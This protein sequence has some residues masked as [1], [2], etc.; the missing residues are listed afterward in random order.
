MRLRIRRLSVLVSLVLLTAACKEET[1]APAATARPV[2]VQLIDDRSALPVRRTTGIV[3]ATTRV[4]VSFEVGG[5][6][7]VLQA[8]VGDRVQAGDVLAEVEGAPLRLAL[9]QAQ[10]EAASVSAVLAEIDNRLKRQTALAARGLVAE[11]ALDAVQAERASALANAE[12]ALSR[13]EMAERDLTLTQVT[14]PIS[15][16]IAAREATPFANVAPGQTIMEID[17]DDVEVTAPIPIDWASGT[18]PGS[19]MT[20]IA[21]DRRIE[22]TLRE[23]SPR[24]VDAGVVEARVTLPPGTGL[25]SGT[26]VRVEFARP[27]AAQFAIPYAALLPGP[28]GTGGHV[29]VIV[30]GKATTRAVTL[31]EV[32]QDRVWVTGGLAPGDQVIVAGAR[33]LT[34]GE[35]VR[36]VA[37]GGAG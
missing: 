25:A 14:A 18:A 7:T 28:D 1:P 34:E 6:I 26:V 16:R 30:D 32:G 4:T 17:G 33:F 12:A 23:I 8:D 3:R 24:V 15:G 19:A 36:P 22:V 29:F 21:G 37:P 9:Q 10:A 5:R 35:A 20:V 27:A 13:I 2:S 11:A 31:A